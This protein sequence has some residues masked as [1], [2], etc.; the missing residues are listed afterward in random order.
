MSVGARRI[1][2]GEHPI[3][4]TVQ[5]WAHYEELSK[6]D[7]H[8]YSR[9][10]HRGRERRSRDHLEG[11]SDNYG[12]GKQRLRDIQGA[13]H[14]PPDTKPDPNRHA[15][16]A[17]LQRGFQERDAEHHAEPSEQRGD[18]DRHRRT[19][20]WLHSKAAVQRKGLAARLDRA[21]AG[22]GRICPTY[23]ML[24]SVSSMRG[25]LPDSPDPAAADASHLPRVVGDTGVLAEVS[26]G[27]F[28]A[29]WKL[30]D[31][32]RDLDANLIRLPP[33]GRIEPFTGPEIDVL[34]VIIQG[35]GTLITEADPIPLSSGEIVWLPARS[36]RGVVAGPDGIGYLTVHQRKQQTLQIKPR[37]V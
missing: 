20:C 19:H 16:R 23:P 11:E 18:G 26:P 31:P 9:N 2:T 4:A 15:G 27:F 1:L 37:S 33:D 3:R 22:T 13:E 34:W 24:S 8:R 30:E 5:P 6:Q 28:G 10:G 12:C 36:L 14:D 21:D 7:H 29:A 32:D 35:G 25:S 17:E